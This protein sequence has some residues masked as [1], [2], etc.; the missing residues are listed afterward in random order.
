MNDDVSFGR[1]LKQR[2]DGYTGIVNFET[3]GGRIIEC[4]LRFT[5]QW[6]DL[7]GRGWIDAV[8]TLYGKGVWRFKDEDRCTGYSVVLFGPHGVGYKVDRTRIRELIDEY[9]EVSSVQITFRDDKP[10]EAHAMPP[11]GFRLA[12]V[13]CWDL[14][15]GF[16]VRDR[17]AL[18]FWSTGHKRIPRGRRTETAAQMRGRQAGRSD[19]IKRRDEDRYRVPPSGAGDRERMDRTS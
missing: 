14:D 17:L 13:N 16:D 2:L 1:W 18:R 19:R 11:G 5:D 7:Y 4:H 3:I 15:V 12:I 10:L 6:P 9:P 8:V